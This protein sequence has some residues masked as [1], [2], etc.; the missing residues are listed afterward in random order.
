MSNIRDP[1]SHK[2]VSFDHTKR[3]SKLCELKIIVKLKIL[4]EVYG[5]IELEKKKHFSHKILCHS[6]QSTFGTN[7]TS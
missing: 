2:N 4:T 5:R 6:Q 3:I 7:K 1:F